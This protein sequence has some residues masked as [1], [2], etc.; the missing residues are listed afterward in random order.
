MDFSWSPEQQKLLDAV[1]SLADEHL[2]KDVI[3]ADRHGRFNHEGWKKCGEFGLQGLPVPIEYGGM[4]QDPLTTV[5][6]LENLGYACK[7]NGLIFSINAH[8]WTVVMPLITTGTEAQKKKYLPGLAN[9]NLI[10]GNAMTEPDAGSDAFSLSTTARRAG[11]NY[12][13]NGRK[14]FVSNGPIADLITVYATVDKSKGVQGVTAFLVEKGTPGMTVTGEIEKMGLRT[15]PTGDL[16]F[17]NCEISE[18]NRIGEDGDG[19]TIFSRSMTWERGSILASSVGSMQRLLETCVRFAR[20]RKQFGHSIGKFQHVADRI[21]DMKV[22][23]ETSR[24]LLYH[25]A[26]L[27]SC[28]KAGF[29]EAAMVKLHLSDC[30]VKS[31]EDAIQIHGGAGYTVELELERELRDAIGSRLYSGTSEIQKNLIASLL[32]L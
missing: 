13:L 6:V 24:R 15:S 23:L 30:W 26:W 18:A 5:G 29:L 32:G 22:R 28:G 16:T 17:E 10:G 3:E 31:C 20:R 27:R 2:R 4:G 11:S 25:S 8:L 21:V 19:S 1:K 14:S 9:G 7:D 12:I